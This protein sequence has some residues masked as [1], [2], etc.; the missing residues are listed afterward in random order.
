MYKDLRGRSPKKFSHVIGVSFSVLFLLFTAF[1]VA[2]SVAYGPA[3]AS[4]VLKNLPEGVF[5]TA[6][7]ALMVLAIAGVYPIMLIPMVAPI[8]TSATW[9]RYQNPIT[10]AIEV[11]SIAVAC[12]V[13][14]LGALNVVNGCLCVGVFVGVIP[15]VVGFF[16]VDQ[17]RVVMAALAA[18]CTVLGVLGFFFTDNYPPCDIE[19]QHMTAVVV[20]C[21]CS[22]SSR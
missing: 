16:F 7:Q 18:G 6:A 20:R 17:A 2:G 10:V 21:W 4:N 15:A 5:G 3:V 13:N 19:K 22:I 14:D 12:F 1:S 9:A 8:R 11:C